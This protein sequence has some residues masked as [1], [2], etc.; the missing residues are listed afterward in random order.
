MHTDQMPLWMCGDAPD[1]ESPVRFRV[2]GMLPDGG[3]HALLHVMASGPYRAWVNG[4]P[5]TACA[6]PRAEQ[7]NAD[8]LVRTG[9][10]MVDVDVWPTQAS[11]PDNAWAVLECQ[12]PAPISIQSVAFTAA[13][14]QS[15][16]WLYLHAV[17]ADGGVSGFVCPET[18]RTD[19][20]LGTEGGSRQI[21]WSPGRE[22][23]LQRPARFNPERVVLLRFR[24]DQKDTR[25]LP[26]GSLR[27]GS[28][29][30]NG[31]PFTPTPNAWALRSGNGPLHAWRLTQDSAGVHVAYRFTGIAPRAYLLLELVSAR[32]GE[33]TGQVITSNTSTTVSGRPAGLEEPPPMD[34]MALFAPKRVRDLRT[35]GMPPVTACLLANTPGQSDV[36]PAGQPWVLH[37]RGWACAPLPDRVLTVQMHDWSGRRLWHTRCLAAASTEMPKWTVTVPAQPMGVYR[38]TLRW[39]GAEPAALG[40]ALLDDTKGPLSAVCAHLSPYRRP[41]RHTGVNLNS[42]SMMQPAVWW[43]LRDMGA[44]LLVVHL[45]PS[46][47]HTDILQTLL[48]FCR[49]TQCRFAINNEAANWMPEANDPT[50]ANTFDAPNGCHRW[51]LDARTLQR[52]AETGLFEGVV[53]DESEHMQMSRN[54]YS[55]LPDRERRK[56]HMV[57]TT[58]MT[59]EQAYDAYLAAVRRVVAYNRAHGSQLIVESV[60]PSLWHPLARAGAV[61]CPKLLKESVYPVVLAECLGAARQYQAP[62]W[63]SPDLWWLG[64]FGGHSARELTHALR[65]AW[66]AG[67]ET[68]YVEFLTMLM[69][70]DGAFYR[71]NAP[72]RALLEHIHRWLPRQR[73]R[74]DRKR[75]RPE[76]ALVHFPAG[77]W[78]QASGGYWN[79]LYGALDLPS[80]P[81]T[82]EHLQAWAWITG[83]PELAQA[84]NANSPAIRLPGRASAWRG[85][86]PSPSVAVY[87]HRVDAQMLDGCRLIVV[88]G[89]APSHGALDAVTHRVKAGAVCIISAR[90]APAGLAPAGATLPF[91]RADG[92]GQ[93]IITDRFD[94]DTL[95]PWTPQLQR[96]RDGM[97]IR[98]DATR[99]IIDSL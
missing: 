60:F 14:A 74:P 63:F 33:L 90:L 43:A 5:L 81:E 37:V 57:E 29:H 53:Y 6:D 58:G 39:R 99:R 34:D 3:D 12:L 97:A 35:P 48:E 23:E 50:G 75:F 93:W 30:L 44:E 22:P 61:L 47:L 94:A 7:W 89:P 54:A 98:Y 46:E 16:E 8:R 42:V 17:D 69:W 32:G 87:D 83:H 51:D 55:G 28:L 70:R 80:T 96:P 85:A 13:G 88:C 73:S 2:E 56:P 31:Q 59:L 91:A 52:C 62:L 66:H 25:A 71:F 15:D 76:V 38:L 21:T 27:I 1:A 64:D 4:K 20:Q 41:V 26:E 68:V 24:I 10:N 95:A 19:L 49:A 77:D 79:M 92:A 86:Y 9:R 67:V 18:G 45:M 72:G 40:Y 36:L 65:L 82:R 11:V 78:G 84:V